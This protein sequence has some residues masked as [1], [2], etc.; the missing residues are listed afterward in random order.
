[1]SYEVSSGKPVAD[2]SP[3]L[4]VLAVAA[5]IG[6]A[7]VLI[8]PR[9]SPF[10]LL[11]LALAPAALAVSGGVPWRD[12]GRPPVA[13]ALLMAIYLLA[14]CLWSEA[15]VDALGKSALFAAIVLAIWLA[16]YGLTRMPTAILER[17]AAVGL[18]AFGAAMLF[19]MFEEYTAHLIKRTVFTLLPFTRPDPKHIASQEGGVVSDVFLYIS[20]RSIGLFTL[21]LWPMLMLLAKGCVLETPGWRRLAA[22]GLLA[23][24][25]ATL[26]KSQHDTS[27]I[28]LALSIV[29]AVVALR[30]KGLALGMVA[31][32]W[33][34]STL[35]VIPI[36]SYA[37]HGQKLY[38][39][40]SLP[41]SARHRIIIW[42]YTAEQIP[43]APLLGIGIESGKL[44]DARATH[45]QPPDHEYPRRTGTHSHNVFVQTW[46][47]LGAVGAVLLCA[48]GLSILVAIGRL[49]PQL[50]PFA[51]G[52]FVTSAAM[53]AFSWGM[54]QPWFM[55]GFGL[56]AMLFM[57]AAE[58]ARR[59]EPRAAGLV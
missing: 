4:G 47:E 1:M 10:V 30:F 26:A 20:N 2:T 19:L 7:V 17:M 48:L 32:A 23:L 43:K 59:A 45:E 36:A 50:Q 44:R 37:Y 22:G 27:V 39:S 38:Q 18:Y 53:A 12:L 5:G 28:A 6:L 34:V 55:A 58:A 3:M 42:G 24:S 13:V 52:A 21:A 9:T 29:A 31:L 57:I 46:Y 35:L 16:R 51:L 15:R 8:F 33:I 40:K 56:C 41:L 11:L 54:W 14:N 49:A 25:A